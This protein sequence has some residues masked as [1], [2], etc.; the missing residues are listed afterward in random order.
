MNKDTFYHITEQF[1]LPSILRAGLLPRRG[2]RSLLIGERQ[3]RVYCFS[4][5]DGVHDALMGW[6]D[7][8]WAEDVPL[9]ILELDAPPRELGIK[10]GFEVHFHGAIPSSCIRRV[11]DESLQPLYMQDH[12]PAHDP[13]YPDDLLLDASGRPIVVFRG[14][15]GTDD[16]GVLQS[17]LP[18][19]TFCSAHIASTYATHSNIGS[20]AAQQPHVYAAHLRMA[21]PVV[22]SDSCFIEFADLVRDFGEGYAHELAVKHQAHLMETGV[23][24]EFEGDYR[25]VGELLDEHPDK[26]SEFYVN[27]YVLLDDPDFIQRAREMGFDGAIHMGNGASFVEREYRIF[28]AHQAISVFSGEPLCRPGDV[29]APEGDTNRKAQGDRPQG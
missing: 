19:I 12:G 27:A 28:D 22:V 1:N 21:N 4:S 26:L 15:H 11:L 9:V 25:N 8:G 17:R 10:D 14:E 5:L 7:M 24:E 29:P 18:S 23:W 13:A 16:T 6:A 3:E 2:A 20:I